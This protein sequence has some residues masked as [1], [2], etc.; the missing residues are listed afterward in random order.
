V[1]EGAADF[2]AS[3]ATPT[4]GGAYDINGVEGP[5]EHHWPVDNSVYTNV[6][7]I[8]T[9]RPATQVAQLLGKQPKAAWTT[10]ADG[11]PVLLDPATGVRPEFEGYVGDTIKQA[12]VVMLT[13][14]WEWQEPASTGLADLNYYAARTDPD[15]PAMTDSIH[16]IDSLALGV[17]GCP[18]YHYTLRSVLPFVQPPYDQFTEAR[19]GQGTFT[20]L[21]GEGGFLQTFLYGWAGFR[22][23]GD[24]IHLDPAL[25]DQ[26]AA[27]GLTLRRL[28]YRGREFSVA[29]GAKRTTVTLDSGSAVTVEGPKGSSTLAPGGT[30]TL[31]TRRLHTAG[32]S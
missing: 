20:F 24:R 25:P 16:A 12:D 10:V 15:G 3:R 4:G 1:L 5:D 21:T 22:W 27:S 17:A 9:L 19:N 23:R 8:T 7:A 18:A 30:M 11:L 28:S 26:W 13:Y 31:P 2:W 6:G 14:P 29:I 32:C